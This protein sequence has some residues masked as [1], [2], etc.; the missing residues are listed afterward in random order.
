M[1]FVHWLALLAGALLLAPAQAQRNGGEL[2]FPVPSEPPS[3]DGTARRRS[4]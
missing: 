3:Y 2:V 1:K 4:A